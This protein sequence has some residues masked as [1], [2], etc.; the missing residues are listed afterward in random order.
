MA[1]IL[2]SALLSVWLILELQLRVGC[3]K[4]MKEAHWPEHG[5]F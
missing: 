1:W 2:L 4:E 3:K 5:S